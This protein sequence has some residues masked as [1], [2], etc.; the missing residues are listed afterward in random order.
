MVS[1]DEKTGP[2]ARFFY[3]ICRGDRLEGV[4]DTNSNDIRLFARASNDI[5]GSYNFGMLTLA[6]NYQDIKSLNNV[7]DSDA[8]IWQVGV[9]VPVGAAGNVHV[10]YGEAEYDFDGE[11]KSKS[12]TLAYTH[13]LSKR[14][15]L[16][17]GFNRT[18][19]DDG[20][21]FGVVGHESARNINTGAAGDE[22][23]VFA[24]GVNHKF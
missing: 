7:E 17:T 16:Y 5:G 4:A 22:S 8:D 14:T 15:T 18:D 21:G 2:K 1:V 3:Q 19:N 12:Y 24:V 9:I 10:A 13:A 6:A 11:S 23:D 20:L